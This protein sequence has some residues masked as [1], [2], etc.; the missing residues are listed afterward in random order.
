[1]SI[2]DKN[3]LFQ[4]I[5]LLKYP[6]VDYF[7]LFIPQ[8]LTIIVSFAAVC[9]TASIDRDAQTIRQSFDLDPEGVYRHEFETD[10]GIY[11]SESGTGGQ[12]A[13]GEASWVAPDGTPIQFSYIADEN[14]Y[15]PTGEHLPTPPPVPAYILRAL[16]YIRLHSTTVEPIIEDAEIEGRS[17][18]SNNVPAISR[19]LSLPFSG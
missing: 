18:N 16:E 7:F 10:N 4:I 14:G 5:V 15:R 8:I 13:Q 3:T 12:Y 9:A 19:D 1:L 2:L 6:F 11:Q 17:L